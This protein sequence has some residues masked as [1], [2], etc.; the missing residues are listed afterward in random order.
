ME[1]LIKIHEVFD[2]ILTLAMIPMSIWI[3]TNNFDGHV[4]TVL[5]NYKI[6]IVFAHLVA[7]NHI[8]QGEFGWGLMWTII[9]A[10]WMLLY[11]K[12]KEFVAEVR[13]RAKEMMDEINKRVIERIANEYGLDIDDFQAVE[14]NERVQILWKGE[15]FDQKMHKKV[16]E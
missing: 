10:L 4:N 13:I 11:K 15:P 9:I 14:E 12:K 2:M 16:E 8:I 1:T 5:R 6:Y 3:F 7:F